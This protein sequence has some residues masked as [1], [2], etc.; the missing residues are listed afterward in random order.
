MIAREE[1]GVLYELGRLHVG[2]N[3][4]RLNLDQLPV[5][6][7]LECHKI[8][9]VAMDVVDESGVAPEHVAEAVVIAAEHNNLA[10]RQQIFIFAAYVADSNFVIHL[11]QGHVDGP[12]ERSHHVE[13]V[14][15]VHDSDRAVIL[16]HHS[17][18]FGTMQKVE[19]VEQLD[20]RLYCVDKAE[21]KA[22]LEAVVA[23]GSLPCS[24]TRSVNVMK[25]ML[26][27]LYL[28]DSDPDVHA[29]EN[30][31]VKATEV[32]GWAHIV[33]IA[34]DDLEFFV[35]LQGWKWGGRQV[36]LFGHDARHCLTGP[37]VHVSRVLIRNRGRHLIFV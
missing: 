21:S 35:L 8:G 23:Q 19:G 3:V 5:V 13:A 24:N 11:L 26:H 2:G 18:L 6:L 25:R 36:G 33:V 1:A 4:G 7:P 15:S 17:P 29:L 10:R 31:S 9:H 28:P 37:R 20:N 34:L 12:V 32:N 14:T 16:Q 27:I 30:S 22:L